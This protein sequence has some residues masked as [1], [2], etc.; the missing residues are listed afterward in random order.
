MFSVHSISLW[1]IVIGL[2]GEVIDMNFVGY[3]VES[4]KS[5]YV[6]LSYVKW[7]SLL[8]NL[9]KLIPRLYMSVSLYGEIGV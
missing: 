5:S 9:G 7:F 2:T 1:I 4:L 8:L 6:D 3:E